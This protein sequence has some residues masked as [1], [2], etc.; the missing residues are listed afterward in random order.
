MIAIVFVGL[1][2]HELVAFDGGK[3]VS[4]LSGPQPR[5]IARDDHIARH[6]DFRF[7]H[8]CGCGL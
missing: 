7:P 8:R 6:Q 3:D 2:Y 1:T 4:I 5:I